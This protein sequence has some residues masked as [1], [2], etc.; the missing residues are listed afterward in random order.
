[1]AKELPFF[2]FEPNQ[3]ENGNIQMCSREARGLFIDMCS[4][5]WS[6]LGDLPLKLAIQ[7]LC[8]GNATALNPLID[9]NIIAINDGQITIEFLDEQLQ[10]FKETSSQNSRNAKKR[11][12]KV[13]P[14]KDL[15]EGNA[16]ASFPQSDGNAIRE[17]KIREEKI[18]NINS[19]KVENLDEINRSL[20]AGEKEIKEIAMELAEGNQHGSQREA[21]MNEHRIKKIEVFKWALS[22]FNRHKRSLGQLTSTHSNY[23]FHLNNWLRKQ[24]IQAIH[25]DYYQELKRQTEKQ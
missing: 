7:K 9:E 23:S 19:E 10:E 2:K 18:N 3:W 12:E 13:K 16:T 14:S 20:V 8:A 11:W 1:M 21:I 17:D 22:L 4:V 24:D 5:Y 25:Q 6:R 15:S